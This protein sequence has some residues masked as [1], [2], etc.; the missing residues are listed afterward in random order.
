[1]LLNCLILRLC[2]Y[3]VRVLYFVELGYTSRF[4]FFFQFDCEY[5]RLR[6]QIWFNPM[7]L[8][9]EHAQLPL[10]FVRIVLFFCRLIHIIHVSQSENSLMSGSE[11]ASFLTVTRVAVSI[12]FQ[13]HDSM[14]KASLIQHQQLCNL[15]PPFYFHQ[16]Q[17]SLY[18]VLLGVF[19]TWH[20]W[21]Q[22]SLHDVAS[23]KFFCA[24]KKFKV[25]HSKLT[26]L[27]KKKRVVYKGDLA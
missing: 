5:K 17:R 18:T 8:G 14:F 11:F 12:N 1:M 21:I 9:D 2:L 22:P 10:I 27:L 24:R 3:F 13:E 19:P 20:S 26:I 4:F 6:T 7:W 16:N 25:S 15:W 23:L